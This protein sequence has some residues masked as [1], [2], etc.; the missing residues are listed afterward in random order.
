MSRRNNRARGRSKKGGNTP[1]REPKLASVVTTNDAYSL[2]DNFLNIRT[3]Y[4]AQNKFRLRESKSSSDLEYG[5][6][7]SGL[8]QKNSTSD[9][10]DYSTKGSSGEAYVEK[11]FNDLSASANKDREN[12]RKELLDKVQIVET[13]VDTLSSEIHTKISTAVFATIIG[14]AAAI[15]IAVTTYLF[16]DNNGIKEELHIIDKSVESVKQEQQYIHKDIE[17]ISNHVILQE[18]HNQAPTKTTK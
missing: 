10:A 14:I 5:R 8:F 9:M 16:T 17:D 6:P 12:L 2:H 13:K 1:T 15:I 7:D 4:P 18:G 11:R 3:A